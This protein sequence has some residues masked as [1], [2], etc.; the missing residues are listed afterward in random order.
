MVATKAG[1]WQGAIRPSCL[2]EMQKSLLE[3]A[4]K[5]TFRKNALDFLLYDPSFVVM[6]REEIGQK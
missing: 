4:K 1:N 2:S 5:D 3:C 6:Y